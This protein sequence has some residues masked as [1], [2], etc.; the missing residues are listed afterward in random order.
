MNFVEIDQLYEF[1]APKSFDFSSLREGEETEEFDDWFVKRS[2]TPRKESEEIRDEPLPITQSTFEAPIFQGSK[3]LSSLKRP[4]ISRSINL[5]IRTQ[6]KKLP[7]K[8]VTVASSVDGGAFKKQRTATSFVTKSIQNTIPSKQSLKLTIPRGPMLATAS[9][10]I[11]PIIESTES[12]ILKEMELNR[13]LKEKKKLVNDKKANQENRPL[14]L[15]RSA[16][17][18]PAIPRQPIT[19]LKPVIRQPIRNPTPKPAPAFKTAARKIADGQQPTINKS[20]YAHV[21]SRYLEFYAP[22]YDFKKREL[23]KHTKDVVSR[24]K[25]MPSAS[26]NAKTTRTN[27]KL[28]V[29]VSP[30]LRT[31]M[32]SAMRPALPAD[33]HAI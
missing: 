1:D 28:T 22:T 2:E 24:S 30:I 23:M 14:N 10:L 3:P 18:K 15:V 12:R 8:K 17:T 31:T 33:L 13:T 4:L 32:R 27:M 21:R 20:Q 6:P 25:V 9:R 19:Q 16:S 29:P 11:R 26:I 5:P 7:E